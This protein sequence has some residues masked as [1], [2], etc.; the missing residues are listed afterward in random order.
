MSLDT[1]ICL[2]LIHDAV[3]KFSNNM[4]GI[5]NSNIL[6]WNGIYIS[7]KFIMWIEIIYGKSWYMCSHWAVST[8]YIPFFTARKETTQHRFTLLWFNI[9]WQT[10]KSE[11]Y[12]DLRPEWAQQQPV[13]I[14][15]D[16]AQ[17]VT[18]YPEL[19]GSRFK[20]MISENFWY[21]VR[22]SQ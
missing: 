2:S 19:Q 11:T 7:N 16:D 3:H 5:S 18:I 12:P 9:W 17:C 4:P 22:T 20:F 15:S 21:L 6:Q 10:Q 1:D 14:R 13:L 8:Q